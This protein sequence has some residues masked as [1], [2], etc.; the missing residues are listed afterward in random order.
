M[1]G[2]PADTVSDEVE[3]FFGGYGFIVV[4]YGGGKY[5]AFSILVYPYTSLRFYGLVLGSIVSVSQ[6]FGAIQNFVD[7]IK[8]SLRGSPFIR[9][10]LDRR[11]IRML[12]HL[13]NIEG[14]MRAMTMGMDPH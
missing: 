14:N 3:E 2:R 1:T 13:G 10:I 6:D 4:P 8:L 7:E 9:H 12:G 11:M 5:F